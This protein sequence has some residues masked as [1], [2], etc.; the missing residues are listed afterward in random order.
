MR[1]IAVGMFALW[2]LAAPVT[3]ADDLELSEVEV[4]AQRA[5]LA[6]LGLDLML[7]RQKRLTRVSSALRYRGAALCEQRWSRVLGIVAASAAEIPAAYRDTAYQ[8]YGVDD[9]VKVLWVLPG[10]PAAEA[11]LRA[12]DT[13]LEIDGRETHFAAALEQSS[14]GDL[15]KFT[16]LKIERT[17]RVRDLQLETRVGC[18]LPAE[19]EILDTIDA[20]TDGARIAVYTGLLRFLES[21]AELAVIL[22]H[23]LAHALL[24]D[25]LEPADAERDADT[26][27]LYLAARAGY[28]ISVARDL[29]ERFV[30][31]FPLALEVRTGHTYLSSP[32][33][34]L[35]LD[36]TTREIQRKLDRGEPL[37][38]ETK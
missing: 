36:A 6:S 10:Y 33:R 1:K 26:L 29:S 30:R 20:Y 35:A 21:D 24:D 31:E 11:G 18:F 2:W 5:R 14:A 8:R 13:I 32:E 12:G 17:G 16:A 22:G 3:S 7:E 25:G 4:A 28:D 9:L 15:P 19:V 38:P 34:S 37:E 27:G 23:E